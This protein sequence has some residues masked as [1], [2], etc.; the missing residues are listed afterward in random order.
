VGIT[1]SQPNAI[2]IR[3][4]WEALPGGRPRLANIIQVNVAGSRPHSLHV[5][6]ASSNCCRGRGIS[7][8]SSM[9][10]FVWLEATYRKAQMNS[11]DARLERALM[12]PITVIAAFLVNASMIRRGLRSNHREY[13]RA[14]TGSL[15]VA[16]LFPLLAFHLA[17]AQAPLAAGTYSFRSPNGSTWDAGWALNPSWGNPN[18]IG[19]FTLNSPASMTQEFNLTTTGK[20]QSTANPSLYLYS[21][22]DYLAL[23]PSGDLFAISTHSHGYVIKDKRTGLYVLSSGSLGPGQ[24]LPLASSGTVWTTVSRGGGGG[25]GTTTIN[26]NDP[27]ILY[28]FGNFESGIGGWVY[29]TGIGT[30][31]DGDQHSTSYQ[32]IGGTAFQGM[33]ASVNFT[34]TGISWI[35]QQGPNFGEFSWS[36]DGG[37]E[38]IGNSFSSTSVNRSTD[39]AVSGLALGSHV[40]RISLLNATTGSDTLQTIDAFQIAGSPLDLSA[41]TIIGACN[42]LESYLFGSWAG[43]CDPNSDGSDGPL[44]AGHVYSGSPGSYLQ[45]TFTGS[46]IEVFGRPD[47]EDGVMNVSVDGEPPVQVSMRAGSVD[48]DTYN[49]MVVFAKKLTSGSHTIRLSPAGYGDGG[50]MWNLIQIVQLVAFP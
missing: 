19:L 49:Y 10:M 45:W 16:I 22:N 29:S 1:R 14:T 8:P 7:R 15:F 2:V 23:G 32:T 40:L 28:S 24:Q 30:D 39:L 27:S 34:G 31:Y 20:L 4:V 25:T 21:L 3:C 33:S 48:N 38:T 11:A 17:Y 50:P 44:P 13:P 6:P 43:G 9:K 42:E 5:E 35:G 41:G 26:D 46:L 12:L 47:F 36:I 18:Y 37:P